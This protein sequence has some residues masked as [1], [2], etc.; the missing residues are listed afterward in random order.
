[1]ANQ[2]Q[3]NHNTVYS[4]WLLINTEEKLH[5]HSSL[6]FSHTQAKAATGSI[7]VGWTGLREGDIGREEET[8]EE[9]TEQEGIKR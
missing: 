2:T 8:T 9:R 4:A 6:S 5:P 1:M 3:S 7:Q